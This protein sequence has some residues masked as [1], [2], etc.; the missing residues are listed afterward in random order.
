MDLNLL[1]FVIALLLFLS[2]LG[3]TLSARLG[4]PLLLVFLGVGILAGEEGI[5]GIRFSGYFLANFIGQAALAI[6]L[7]DGGLILR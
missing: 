3:S 1:Y 2:I 4:M 7:L 5:L 6:I